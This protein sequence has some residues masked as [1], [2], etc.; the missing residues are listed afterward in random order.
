MWKRDENLLKIVLEMEFVW[1]VAQKSLIQ[2]AQNVTILKNNF[3]VR[4]NTE[5]SGWFLMVLRYLTLTIS[6][7]FPQSHSKMSLLVNKVGINDE[8]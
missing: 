6:S 5:K 3:F 8:S 1:N 2:N 7:T 4:L